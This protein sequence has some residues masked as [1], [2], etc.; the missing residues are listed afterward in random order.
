MCVELSWQY[1]YQ[2]LSSQLSIVV[3]IIVDLRSACMCVSNSQNCKQIGSNIDTVWVFKY[4]MYICKL[5]ECIWCFYIVCGFVIPHECTTGR[6]FHLRSL[7]NASHTRDH[8]VS[9]IWCVFCCSATCW[10]TLIVCIRVYVGGECLLC[11]VSKYDVK[12]Y[13]L[14]Y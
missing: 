10:A 1:D 6:N 8:H 4:L 14:N 5:S 3:V 11:V 12:Y 9:N 2:M 13:H 7:E